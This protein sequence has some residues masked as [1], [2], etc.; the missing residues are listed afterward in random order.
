MV[1]RRRKGGA[2]E[3]RAATEGSKDSETSSP[4]PATSGIAVIIVA[5]LCGAIGGAYGGAIITS[6]R[7]PP[8]ASS[9]P[10]LAATTARWPQSPRE[11]NALANTY[12]EAAVTLGGTRG[13]PYRGMLSLLAAWS[14]SSPHGGTDN[15]QAH[16]HML[17]QLVENY[18]RSGSASARD[19]ARE[20]LRETLYDDDACSSVGCA[21]ARSTAK[22]LVEQ[23]FG[24]SDAAH[25]RAHA[26]GK[27]AAAILRR[28]RD[29][30]EGLG[31]VDPAW[32]IRFATLSASWF[33]AGRA[34]RSGS[35]AEM[36]AEF[37]QAV[38]GIHAEFAT[39]MRAK[40][41][42]QAQQEG[43]A[44][45][46]DGE[47]TTGALTDTQL[48]NLF[49]RFQM[50][51]LSDTGEYFSGF[52]QTALF[53]AVVPAARD[54]CARFLEKHGHSRRA[55]AAKAAGELVFWVSVHTSRSE[56]G[57]H[58]T[59]DSLVGGVYYVEVPARSG[60]LALFDPRGKAPTA[61]GKTGGGSDGDG[62]GAAAGV[63]GAAVGGEMPPD[64]TGRHFSGKPL[65]APPFHR[66]DTV[67][68]VPGLLVLFPG[69]LVHQV[70]PAEGDAATELDRLRISIS[71]NLKGEWQ[72]TSAVGFDD[73]VPL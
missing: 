19:L 68:P 11:R 64:P 35:W 6:R 40:A 5:V 73:G 12:L 39:K 20:V 49:F 55:A 37:Y 43:D 42:A 51:V 26:H 1:A 16:A 22:K 33:L 4:Y 34:G 65:P 66:V 14:Y 31:G 17:T 15:H 61:A 69:W 10:P 18:M 53:K 24:G 28:R 67:R 59:A 54:A 8:G 60:A 63:D 21:M 25:A 13:D 57:P 58:N 44:A 30:T 36:N 45:S 9:R 38:A 47:L 56:H 32:S 52:A 27:R 7:C 70:L 2:N 41:K 71:L 23:H 48:N 50:Q 3:K 72:D 46:G 62:E 29:G